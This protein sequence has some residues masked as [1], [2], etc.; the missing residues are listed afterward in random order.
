MLDV[1]NAELR[2]LVAGEIVVAFTTRAAVREG[3]E[4]DLAAGAAL[5]P[6][7]L[8]PAY[9]RWA[10]AP[11]PPGDWTAVVVAVHPASSLS[12]DSG[13]ARHVRRDAPTGGDLVVLRVYDGDRP[14]LSDEAFAARVRSLQGAL[15]G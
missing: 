12:P 14:V 4:V 6:G 10:A 2:A 15:T 5:D 3:D 1:P 8:K 7:A 11:A 9:A 13:A